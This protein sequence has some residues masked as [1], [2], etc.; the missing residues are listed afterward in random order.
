MQID[1]QESVLR[2]KREKRRKQKTR[3][4][5][6]L[7]LLLSYSLF[8]FFLPFLLSFQSRQRTHI[9]ATVKQLKEISTLTTTHKSGYFCRRPLNRK[10]SAKWVARMEM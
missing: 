5:I 8:G 2:K 9:Q 4:A 7:W 1:L 3:K 10:A 6:C